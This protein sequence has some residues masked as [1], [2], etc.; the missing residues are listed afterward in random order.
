MK[1]INVPVIDGGLLRFKLAPSPALGV[2]IEVIFYVSLI[3][4]D[5]NA[6]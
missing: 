3:D 2:A 4:F 1:A 5:V 6:S